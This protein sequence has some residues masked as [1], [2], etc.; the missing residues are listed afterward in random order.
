MYRVET[1]STGCVQPV[2]TPWFSSAGPGRQCR[3]VYDPHAGHAQA[4]GQVV[5][6][7]VRRHSV[8]HANFEA[9]VAGLRALRECLRLQHLATSTHQM[10]HRR[11]CIL[12]GI[13][14]REPKKK[15]Q[16]QNKTYYHAKDISFLAH[17]PL[18]AKFR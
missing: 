4:A 18:L 13:H 15:T 14:P 7:Q 3:A 1:G 5:C 12:K 16:G 17:D 2:F 10:L 8:V 6:L 11:L 9:C